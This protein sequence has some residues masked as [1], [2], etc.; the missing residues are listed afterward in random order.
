[1]SYVFR[2]WMNF[3]E[4]LEEAARVAAIRSLKVREGE[5]VLIVANPEREV[6]LIACA[7]SDA[8]AD[9][10]G[11]PILAYQPVKSQF[12][13]TEDEVVAAIAALPSV[14]VS[15]SAD[16]L[17]KDRAAI[18][19]PFSAGG[20]RYDSTFHYLLYGRKSV[21]SFWSPHV[22]VDCFV[23]A[24][25]IDY[26]ALKSR[27]L[28]LK[29]ILDGAVSV[30]VTNGN[31][32]D[33]SFGTSGRKAFTDDGDFS[34]PGAGGNLPA[35]E[36]FISPVTGTAEGL[37]VFDGSIASHRGEILIERP[38]EARIEKGFVTGLSGGTEADRLSESLEL[39]TKNALDFEKE[40]KLPSGM[41]AEYAKNAR[42]IGELGIGLNDRAKITGNMLEDEKVYR[43]CHFAIGSNYDDDAPALIHLDGLVSKPTVTV[44]LEGGKSVVLMEDGEL[45]LP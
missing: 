25:P 32:T 13:F 45:T 28:R 30:R 35:G 41:G 26:E 24:V 15:L 5:R 4:G 16:R 18:K 40:G 36:T 39:G 29:D 17:G 7:L 10:G 1:M 43:T 37:V 34:F 21:R 42:N 22:T 14:I 33:V 2:S 11:R 9:A 20:K 6:G 27:C 23:R 3:P 44:R 19:S 31:G 8:V 38:I 12:D